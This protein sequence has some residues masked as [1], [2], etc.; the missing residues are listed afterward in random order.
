LFEFELIVLNLKLEGVKR[1]LRNIFWR[2][3]LRSYLKYNFLLALQILNNYE[4]V[5]N[6]K[7]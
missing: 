4:P 1:I 7:P 6:N 5:E 3:G 2:S